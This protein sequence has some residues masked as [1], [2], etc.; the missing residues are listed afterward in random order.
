MNKRINKQITC[1][2]THYDS[3]NII[4]HNDQ[5]T[6]SI[7]DYTVYS[8]TTY[9]F[10]HNYDCYNAIND[11]NQRIKSTNEYTDKLMQK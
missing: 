11:N 6:K 2:F 1:V 10:L 5:G 4:N 7:N 9:V 3:Y 8:Q